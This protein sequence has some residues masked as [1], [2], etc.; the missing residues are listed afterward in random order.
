MLTSWIVSLVEF[1]RR[2]AAGVVALAL[3]MTLGC[4]WY[5]ATHFRINTD[6]NQLLS[7]DLAW[8]RQEKELEKAFPQKTD[9]LLAVIDGDTPEAAEMAAHALADKLATRPDLFLAVERPDSIPFFRKNGLLFLPKDQLA[10]ILDQIVQAQPL[11]GAVTADPSLRG[12][13][14]TV[15]LMAQGAKAGQVETAR[16]DRPFAVIADTMEAAL[17]GQEKWLSLQ[18][19]MSAEPPSLRE[20]RK[21]IV[22]H[23]VLDYQALEPGRAASDALRA[24]AKDLH[25]SP[26][27]GV[28]V[29]LTGS[30]ALNDEEFASVAEGTG[31][32]T[33]L[34]AV[35]VI[36][37]L[38]LALR[39]LRL[40][41]PILITL[42]AGLAATTA[43]ALL[44]VG[45]LNLISVAFAVMFIG[46]G[47]DFGI[48]FGVRY[49][50]QHHRDPDH[51][52]AMKN[53]AGLIAIPLAMAA[54]STSLG[55]FAFLP[56]DYRGV[57]E[58]GLIA[59]G[60]M[61]IAF[62]LNLTL[63]PALLTLV[64]PP[65]EPEA[66]GYRWAAP[67]DR[68]LAARRKPV[69]I[70]ALVLALAGSAVA[71]RVQFDFDP[72][73]LK[74]PKSESVSTLFELMR[75]PDFGASTLDVLRPSL[76][77]AEELAHKLSTLPEVDHAMTLAS[78]VPEDQEDRLALLADTRTLLE[79]TLSLPR[80]SP[81]DHAAIYDSMR[82]LSS[83]LRALGPAPASAR[84]LAAAL[85]ETVKR[86]DPALLDRLTRMIVGVL[87]DRLRT[88][89]SLLDAAPVTVQSIDDDLRRNWVAPDGRYLVQA[90]PK[91]DPRDNQVLTRFI[92]A[93]RAVAPDAAGSPVSIRESG[94]TV[95]RAF[96]QA[97]GY[98]V[99]A[100][101]LLAYA[102][103]RRA[104]DVALMLAP[105][106]LA[107][108]LTLATIVVI[109][110]P[111]NF[112]NIIAL[113]LLLSLGVSYAIY[114]VSYG[115]SGAKNPLQ[116]SMARAVLF[117]AAT[118]LVAFGS[119]A[120]SSH[121]GTAGMGKLLTV[122]LLYSL[123]STFFLL[124]SL[125]ASHKK[126][127]P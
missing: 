102:V 57:S 42:A 37:L 5:A 124:P 116:S 10:D 47:V 28:R 105:L 18:S 66:V 50:D 22:A 83:A 92:D 8:R 12:F 41:V 78:F 1:S 56:T 125:L 90:Y 58:L 82:R 35:L 23:P 52:R 80:L 84:R 96:L 101:A 33:A 79:P 103:L 26:E 46:I 55:F 113:P 7:D 100:I 70:A 25:L 85:E 117:S 71:S 49:R 69:L 14:D 108:I 115:R 11:L 109:G 97:G 36:L 15:A 87:Q 91:G 76:H 63:L 118:V 72:L 112:A 24:I 3:I 30:V 121:P 44:A 81:P 54:G 111:L 17:A 60:G 32:A 86:D 31:G 53:T 9:V 51:A 4:G 27:Q 104:R 43:F 61:L 62:A 94:R 29:R 13:F 74:D 122:A 64:R 119:L 19:M 39:S 95:T 34:S 77:E 67:A 73:N 88:V 123:T 40:V 98:A 106:I 2:Q 59:G 89:R 93:V 20:L 126:D 68:F 75:D 110:L 45:S 107:G 16:L 48:Q 38:F 120:I 127:K 65:A 99:L 114:F 21:Y 6:I